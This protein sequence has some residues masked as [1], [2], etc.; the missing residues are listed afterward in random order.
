MWNSDAFDLIKLKDKVVTGSSIM[1][2][3]KNP[4]TLEYL[5]GQTGIVYGNKSSD[6]RGLLDV[7]CIF[8]VYS[9]TV[10]FNKIKSLRI[11]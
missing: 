9:Q 1:P 5:R 7:N 4:D 2:Q 10:G 11:V 6:Q 8:R 3:K